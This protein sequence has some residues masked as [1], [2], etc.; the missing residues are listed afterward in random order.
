MD[1]MASAK[2]AK[3]ESCTGVLQ[4]VSVVPS[5][6]APSHLLMVDIPDGL[7]RRKRICLDNLLLKV[8]HNKQNSIPDTGH[9]ARWV[10]STTEREDTALGKPKLAF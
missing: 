2:A 3:G 4:K 1:C 9:P 10:N 6:L 7:P 8:M 5:A